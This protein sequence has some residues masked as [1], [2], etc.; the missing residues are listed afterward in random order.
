VATNEAPDEP[1]QSDLTIPEA[2]ELAVVAI[3]QSRVPEGIQILDQVLAAVP[4][5]VDALHYKGMA[6]YHAHLRS[7]EGIALVE[8]AVELA[9]EYCDAWNN[10]GNIRSQ[11]KRYA[12]AE[13]AYRRVL[14]LQPEHAQAWTNLSTALRKQDRLPEAEAAVLQALSLAPN[15]PEALHSLGNILHRLERHN[16]ALD[17]YKKSLE[18]RPGYPDGYRKLAIAFYSVGQIKEAA[19]VYQKWLTL[20]PE[21]PYPIHMLAACAQEDVPDRASDQYVANVFDRFAGSFDEVLEKLQYRAPELVAEAVQEYLGQGRHALDVAD[22]GCGTGLCGPLL[23][24]FAKSLVGVDLSAGMIANA[25]ER[26]HDDKPVYDELHVAEL[27]AFFSEHPNNYDLVVS[28]DTL[29]YFGKLDEAMKAFATSLRPNGVLGFTVES[30]EEG[31]APEGYVI[32]PH[33]RY[34]QTET[35]VRAM[36]KQAGL[37]AKLVNNVQLRMESGKPVG[38]LLV[39]ARKS[40]AAS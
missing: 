30:A 28:A 15:S 36:L 31:S 35:Y 27:T 13:A 32:G 1:K 29:C 5:H 33:G 16:E 8:R 20:E 12:E 37:S 23:S 34:S 14:T 10:L 21:N 18:L 11:T 17:A 6:L 2:L 40:A 19:V 7:T 38:G 22:A 39:L 3:R 24:T 26:K 9:P 4:E 25:K